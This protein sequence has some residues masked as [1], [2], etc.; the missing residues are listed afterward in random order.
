MKLLEKELANHPATDKLAELALKLTL[1]K[2]NQE[3]IIRV[4]YHA[5]IPFKNEIGKL[6]STTPLKSEVA[7]LE[8]YSQNLE[9]QQAQL[10]TPENLEKLTKQKQVLE[11]CL[12]DLTD[13]EE[14]NQIQHKLSQIK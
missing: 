11:N 5:N 7:R 1:E 2:N 12:Q 3:Y 14:F 10:P 6:I 8:E 4:H 13:E 9:Q